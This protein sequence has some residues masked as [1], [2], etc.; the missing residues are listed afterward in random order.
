MITPFTAVQ[1]AG[2]DVPVDPDMVADV[3][4][5][6]RLVR[7]DRVQEFQARSDGIGDGNEMRV[8]RAGGDLV[9][10]EPFR[11]GFRPWRAGRRARRRQFG[12]AVV[13]RV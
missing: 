9:E 13:A 12:L 4:H 5:R 10:Q 6:E 8:K 1:V 7:G 2:A 3:E 11:L